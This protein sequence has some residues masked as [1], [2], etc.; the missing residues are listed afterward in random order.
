MRRWVDVWCGEVALKEVY[1]SIF[2]IALHNEAFVADYMVP[3]NG[4]LQWDVSFIRAAQDWEV[5]KI[6]PFYSTF[7]ALN[8]D[9]GM[10]DKLLWMHPGNKNLQLD[11]FIMYVFSSFHCLPLE[12]YLGASTSCFFWLAGLMGK[13]SP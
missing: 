8:L 2:R 9:C 13:F 5:R 12:A 6:S 4:P 1:P 7:Y 3:S 10:E 11:P